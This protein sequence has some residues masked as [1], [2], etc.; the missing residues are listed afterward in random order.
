MAV[1]S[2]FKFIFTDIGLHPHMRRMD[3]TVF[4]NGNN[5]T[6]NKCK[7]YTTDE[8]VLNLFS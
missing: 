2:R 4:N 7:L 5:L 3:I 1:W 8:N 6:A